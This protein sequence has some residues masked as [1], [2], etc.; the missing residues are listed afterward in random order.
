MPSNP[1]HI[2]LE[3][4]ECGY[5]QETV[6]K[7]F[8]LSLSQGEIGSLLGP[9]GCGKT[10][11]LR[12][13]AGF[14]S[15]QQGRI[16]LKGEEISTP[17]KTVR[18]ELR[19]IGM[20]FQDY[21]LFPH[22]SILENVCFGL[23]GSKTDKRNK[24][25]DFLERVHLD[26]LAS[27]HPHELSGGQ[28]Q[29]VAIARALAPE[30]DILLMDEP[31]SNLDTD[32]RKRLSTE[33][34]ELLKQ[35]A[36]TAILVTHDQQEAFAMADKVAVINDGELK[37]W[38]SPFNLYHNPSSRFVSTFVGDGQFISGTAISE[39]KIETEAG[40]MKSQANTHWEKGD[41]LDVLI[42]P[43]DISPDPHSQCKA[44]IVSKIFAGATILYSIKLSKG[45]LLD[46]HF[47]SNLNFDI[48]DT[49]GIQINI[50]HL[51]AFKI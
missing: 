27:R 6:I 28:Q 33:V 16:T 34:R 49:I 37:Q 38:D 1:D 50:P 10:T 23:K 19:H 20:I 47:P 46:A 21:A 32:L 25:L 11:L 3:R 14:S 48:G 7:N 51:T 44:E 2:C 9:S 36:T 42:R 17:N 5:E 24:A 4:V 13:I 35:N 18:P 45:Q 22:L 39:Q 12:S 29:R 31:F 15:L 41:K 40:T 8:S 26:Q 30:P 43:G